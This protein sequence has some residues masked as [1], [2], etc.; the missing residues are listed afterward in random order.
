VLA[1]HDLMPDFNVQ[2]L[3]TGR[4]AGAAVVIEHAPAAAPA[5]DGEAAPPSDAPA[6]RSA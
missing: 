5:G 1:F 3:G 4:M 6:A 2:P